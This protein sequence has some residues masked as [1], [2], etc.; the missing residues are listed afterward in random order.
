MVH[1]ALV[2]RDAART[3]RAHALEQICRLRHPLNEL[4]R[5]RFGRR[6]ERLD[7]D[8]L[9]LALEEIEQAV[10][11]PEPEIE[12]RATA[13]TRATKWRADER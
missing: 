6:S 9:Q 10:A 8:Q 3:E 13:R 4:Q 11:Q 12:K 5:A 1:S 7:P 2:E